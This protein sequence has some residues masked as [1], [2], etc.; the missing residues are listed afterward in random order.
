PIL[1]EDSIAA[2]K[3][4]LAAERQGKYREM[5]LAMMRTKDFNQD[6]LEQIAKSVGLDVARFKKDMTDPAFDAHIQR[7]HREAQEANVDAT[8]GFF[9]N[10]VAL[11]GYSEERLE[12]MMKDARDKL[13]S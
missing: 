11:Q 9:I 5:H 1:H 7:V 3:A 10:G 12:G 6:H 4:A 13:K 8:P 2:S